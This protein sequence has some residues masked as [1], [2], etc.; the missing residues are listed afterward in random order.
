MPALFI[1]G[2]INLIFGMEKNVV[3]FHYD[4][5]IRKENAILATWRNFST[6]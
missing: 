1:D 3:F 6:F 4:L 2:F 5:E